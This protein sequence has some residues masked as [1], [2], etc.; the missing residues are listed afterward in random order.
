M[1]IFHSYVKLS[2]GI[3][4]RS[5]L[6]AR[7]SGDDFGQA[8][9]LHCC[10]ASKRLV[11]KGLGKCP[12]DVLSGELSRSPHGHPAMRR[13]A[14]NIKAGCASVQT[15]TVLIYSP[16]FSGACPHAHPAHI[17]WLGQAYVT[18]SDSNFQRIGFTRVWERWLYIFWKLSAY[19]NAVPPKLM[20]YWTRPT[21]KVVPLQ[22]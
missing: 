7:D 11:R 19:S 20:L 6:S 18:D 9:P 17:R 3:N 14:V 21:Y 13:L 2:E 22:V 1:V 16:F 4:F 10:N 15:S 5:S 12:E 8:V